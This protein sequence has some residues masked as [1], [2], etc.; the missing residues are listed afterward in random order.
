VFEKMLGSILGGLQQQGAFKG[1]NQ[2]SVFGVGHGI[3]EAGMAV[4]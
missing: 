1:F 4:S 2:A 3:N